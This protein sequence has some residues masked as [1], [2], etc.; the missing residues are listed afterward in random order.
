MTGTRHT[1]GSALAMLSGLPSPRPS[2]DIS[3]EV[4]EVFGDLLGPGG[5]FSSLLGPDG[6]R[7]G[8][9]RQPPPHNV[10]VSA[11][12]IRIEVP[13]P[14]FNED[15]IEVTTENAILKITVG[16]P[17]AEEV[18]G[19][20]L[21]GENGPEER[22][23][24]RSFNQDPFMLAFELP[25]TYRPDK[26]SVQLIKGVLTVFVNRPEEYKLRSIPINGGKGTG[27]ALEDTSGGE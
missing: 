6:P 21:H 23:I 27:P 11:D 20:V 22:C 13:V 17:D 8:G 14:G 26:V 16:D 19:E 15:D 4:A 18:E 1:P 7:G 25:T 10:F 3:P 24:H 2:G 9:R 12:T 5:L